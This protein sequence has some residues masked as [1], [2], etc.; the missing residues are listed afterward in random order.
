MVVTVQSFLG[1]GGKG[2]GRLFGCV[3]IGLELADTNHSG[4]RNIP[5]KKVCGPVLEGLLQ[6]LSVFYNDSSKGQK[7]CTSSNHAV[8]VHRKHFLLLFLAVDLLFIKKNHA[9]YY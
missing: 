7:A 5:K 9:L 4:V 2:G 6:P 3:V 8:I 1:V